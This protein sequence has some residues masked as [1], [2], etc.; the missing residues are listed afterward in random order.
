MSDYCQAC[1]TGDNTPHTCEVI[2]GQQATI[3]R[4]KAAI[5][6]VAHTCSHHPQLQCPA[7]QLDKEQSK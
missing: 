5:D 3:D 6:S 1:E 4:L 2:D 7:C